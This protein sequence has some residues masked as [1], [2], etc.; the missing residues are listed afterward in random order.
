MN[1]NVFMVNETYKQR[2][3]GAK[4]R[5]KEAIYNGLDSFYNSLP[6]ST[7]IDGSP[8]IKTKNLEGRSKDVGFEVID[9]RD[10]KE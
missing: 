1:S 6:F 3:D 2:Y 7:Y 9:T 8:K 4:E 10:K 5:V